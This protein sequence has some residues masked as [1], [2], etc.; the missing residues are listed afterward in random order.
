MYSFQEEAEPITFTERPV[1]RVRKGDGEIIAFCLSRDEA[2]QVAAALN[3][4]S[5]G[6]NPL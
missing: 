6:A 3:E 4:F 1:W 2:M 5:L